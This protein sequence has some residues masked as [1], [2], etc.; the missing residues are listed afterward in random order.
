M[1][2]TMTKSPGQN[3]SFDFSQE[4]N[5]YAVDSL[6]NLNKLN[7]CIDES[8]DLIHIS[9][10]RRTGRH[11]LSCLYTIPRGGEQLDTPDPLT[12]LHMLSAANCNGPNGVMRSWKSKKGSIRSSPGV[13]E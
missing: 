6:N 3:D 7:L 12:A 8:Q 13:C 5:L 2:R 4:G 1:S 11:T 10:M 9:T